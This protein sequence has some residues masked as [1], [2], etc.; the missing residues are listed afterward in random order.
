MLFWEALWP[1][2]FTH[3]VD[4]LGGRGRVDMGVIERILGGFVGGG[5]LRRALQSPS[6]FDWTT[7]T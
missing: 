4:Q 7:R 3:T 1:N 2:G 6:P 5:P